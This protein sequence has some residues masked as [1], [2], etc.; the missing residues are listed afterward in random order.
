M[1]NKENIHI[2]LE[3]SRDKNSGNLT[4][5]TKFDPNAPNFE[6]DETGFSWAPTDEERQFI[7]E[8]FDM[9][10]KK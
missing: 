7:N 8:A 1:E 10:E 5:M 6:K 9:I 4:L 2:K 3:I